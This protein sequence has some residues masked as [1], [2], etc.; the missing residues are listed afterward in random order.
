[1][2][3]NQVEA[4]RKQEE[5]RRK[6]EE[7]KVR[8]SVFLSFFSFFLQINVSSQRKIEEEKEAKRRAKEEEKL[9]IVG[10]VSKVVY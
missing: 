7:K 9:K 2:T 10:F 5:E 1:M 4:K 6:E 8:D 3:H